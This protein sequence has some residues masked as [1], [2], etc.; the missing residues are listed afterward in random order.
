MP[1]RAAGDLSGVC[2]RAGALARSGTCRRA[3][4]RASDADG[5]ARG[6]GWAPGLRR[7]SAADVDSFRRS[8]GHRDISARPDRPTRQRRT[9]ARRGRDRHA[10]RGARRANSTPSAPRPTPARKTSA[11]TPS[12][13]SS[14]ATSTT[15]TS[16]TTAAGSA[17]S[18]RA[19]SATAC[20][21][22]PT[23]STAKRSR[24]AC[25]RP[26]I[27][28]PPKSA[29]RAASIRATPARP[30]S[31]SSTPPSA[32]C[33]DIHVHAFSP[34]EVHH[35]ATSLGLTVGDYLDRLRGAGLGS[36]PGTAAEIL[37]DEVRAVLCPDKLSTAAMARHRRDGASPRPSHH[38]D[39]HV[40]PC[41]PAGALGAASAAHPRPAGAHRRLHR[42]RAAAVRAHGSAALSEGPRPQGP[43]LPRDGADARGVAAGAASADPEHPGV[44]GEAWAGR[45]RRLPQR[46]RQRSRRHA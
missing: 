27:A 5:F 28:A 46:R 7:A 15:P 43:D 23:I 24:A 45:R 16:A 40:R 12:A 30:I 11:A 17:P 19:S 32:P 2:A 44:V 41:R 37:D 42:I 26:G 9:S 33:S 39:H 14:T 3:V 35:G 22:R 38:R 21:A 20:A 18:P 6:E 13:T 31:R 4:L 29:C 8:A 36:L 34:L 1:D 25:A 10:V